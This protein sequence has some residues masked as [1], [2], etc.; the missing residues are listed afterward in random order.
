MVDYGYDDIEK[1]I[2]F[3]IDLESKMLDLTG[4]SSMVESLSL[5]RRT[6]FN[7]I[8]KNKA[9]S[10]SKKKKKVVAAS[11]IFESDE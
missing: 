8:S 2:G 10:L 4:N 1:W 9:S 7:W 5:F 3:L 6:K 11:E